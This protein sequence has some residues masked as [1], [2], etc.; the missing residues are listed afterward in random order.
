MIGNAVPVKLA[1]YVANCLLMYIREQ[2]KHKNY[3]VSWLSCR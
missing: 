1:E 2:D 3:H